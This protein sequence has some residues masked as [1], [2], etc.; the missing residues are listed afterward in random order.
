VHPGG[1]VLGAMSLGVLMIS[2]TKADGFRSIG[3]RRC[4][5]WAPCGGQEVLSGMATRRDKSNKDQEIR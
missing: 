3:G 4:S 1:P 2:A 5:D